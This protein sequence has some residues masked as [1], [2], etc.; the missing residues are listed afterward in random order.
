METID[1]II[2]TLSYFTDSDGSINAKEVS[3][4]YDLVDDWDDARE[5]VKLMKGCRYIATP[6]HTGPT[7]RYITTKKGT[8]YL[9]FL[10]DQNQ[11][12]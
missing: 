6:V 1:K 10:Q 2:Y 11:V 4:F 5:I 3:V 12:Q 7:V 8:E 9:K